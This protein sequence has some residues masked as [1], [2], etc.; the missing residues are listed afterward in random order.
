MAC[1]G[2][3]SNRAMALRASLSRPTSQLAF[4]RIWVNNDRIHPTEFSPKGGF[5][6]GIAPRTTAS[7]RYVMRFFKGGHV[8]LFLELF[9]VGSS[10]VAS[11]SLNRVTL[12]CQYSFSSYNLCERPKPCTLVPLWQALVKFQ[13]TFE[14]RAARRTPKKWLSSI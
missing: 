13:A 12:S 14:T 9:K 7:F 4:R 2:R 3:P 11:L 10:L 5:M 8:A 6:W 1:F